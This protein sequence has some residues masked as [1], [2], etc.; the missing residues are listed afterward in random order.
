MPS[1]VIHVRLDDWVLLGCHDVMKAGE[2][3]V[4][5]IPMSTIVR[6]VLTAFVR[7][8]Q[9]S[10]YIPAYSVEELQERINEIHQ[11]ELDV[12]DVDLN[13]FSGEVDEPESDMAEL[14]KQVVQ[15]IEDE[16][17]PE[18]VTEEVLIQEVSEG[19]KRPIINIFD[20][21]CT[22]FDE[23]EKEAPK[24]RLIEWANSQEDQFL[25]DI[26]KQAVGIVYTSLPKTQWGS[27]EAKENVLSLIKM[28][29]GHHD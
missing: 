22:D 12:P 11:G 8:M 25:Q 26:Q 4:D 14:A 2:K 20:I 6:E 10:D 13:I 24:D 19:I 3:L 1:R 17:T 16:G 15:K 9:E 21:P 5:G 27:E 7:K 18:N 29:L 23:H 28:H